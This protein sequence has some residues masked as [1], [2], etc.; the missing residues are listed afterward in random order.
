MCSVVLMLD[1][2]RLVLL[3]YEVWGEMFQCDPLLKKI[4]SKRPA[5]SGLKMYGIPLGTL[6]KIIPKRLCMLFASLHIFFLLN[7]S[8]KGQSIF[9]DPLGNRT[10][11]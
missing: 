11:Q 10:L 2:I 1:N 7:R 3:K 6:D 9:I 4:P 8:I 5:L